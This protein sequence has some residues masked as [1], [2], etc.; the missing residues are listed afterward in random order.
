MGASLLHNMRILDTAI[1]ETATSGSSR[2]T[3]TVRSVV[4]LSGHSPTTQRHYLRGMVSWFVD[5][6]VIGPM[7]GEI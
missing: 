1:R 6:P 7:V 4:A 3:G 2:Q 5:I